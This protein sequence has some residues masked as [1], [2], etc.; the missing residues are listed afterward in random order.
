MNEY[1]NITNIPFPAITIMSEVTLLS[2]QDLPDQYQE[3]LSSI[4]FNNLIITFLIN[5]RF[6]MEMI[7][8]RSEDKQE[9]YEDDRF[10]AMKLPKPLKNFSNYGHKIIPYARKTINR[11]R[12]SDIGI[13]WN[14]EYSVTAAETI[15]SMVLGLSVNIVPCHEMFEESR[16]VE[17]R[18]LI[19]ILSQ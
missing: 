10:E 17:L 16:Y 3:E 4:V 13:I 15:T 9:F 18:F 1:I 12:L 6:A 5:S 7:I 11:S 19:S 14:E 8:L 2:Y